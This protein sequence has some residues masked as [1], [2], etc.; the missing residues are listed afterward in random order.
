LGCWLTE[1]RLA[2]GSAL[3]AHARWLTEARC[4]RRGGGRSA[5]G[6]LLL[7][8]WCTRALVLHIQ[9]IGMLVF[10]VD[11]ILDGAVDV[12]EDSL[13][14][15]IGLGSCLSLELYLGC[16]SIEQCML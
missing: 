12:G 15:F 14:S 9:A 8:R 4:C 1:S 3:L 13:N 10:A 7:G 6:I 11:D 2:K 16:V 5:K